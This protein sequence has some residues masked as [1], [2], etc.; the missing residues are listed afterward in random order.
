MNAL[1]FGASGQ[2]GQYLAELC[3]ANGIVPV[4]VSR[5]GSGTRAD[6]ADFD[7]VCGVVR[8][9]APGHIFHLAAAS[10]TRHD[11]LFENHRAISTGTLNILEAA[12]RHCPGARI[13]L[14]GSGVQFVNSGAPISELAPFEASSPY[15][16]AR[17]QSVYAGRYFR[18]LGLAVYVGYLFHHE[19]PL[20]K[21][22]HVSQMVASAARR[23][24]AGSCERIEVGDVTV[25]K[26]WTFA[27]DVARAML[28]LVG[29]DT[30]LEAA[31][32][33]GTTH[34]IQEW[35]EKC[36]GLVGKDWR[37]QVRIREGF[38]SEYQRLVSDPA[39]I[40]SLGW[41]PEV[42]FDELARM[43]VG[44]PA[45]GLGRAIPSVGK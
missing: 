21:P 12:R 40:R 30:V 17:I 4:G 42:G 7:Q 27:G 25:E 36:F 20:R 37:D 33:V 6:V 35:L 41:E 39:T 16:V 2:D 28:A 14:A 1:I 22:S 15:A 31:I 3:R 23:A 32:G 34:T 10:T 5:S 9:H 13:F 44:A 11:A 26:E 18:S 29:Q 38:A 19:S 8:Q 43:M 24:A 45:P